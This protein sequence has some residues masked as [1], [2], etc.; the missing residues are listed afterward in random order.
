MSEHPGKAIQGVAEFLQSFQRK[1]MQ[2]ARKQYPCE[3]SDSGCKHCHG[4]CTSK[5]S[6][7]YYRV[8]M[9]DKTGVRFCVGC[10]S[11]ALESGLFDVGLNFYST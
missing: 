7:V 11:D 10:A 8:D 6:R 5:R 3:C 4:K 2:R 9:E 1:P